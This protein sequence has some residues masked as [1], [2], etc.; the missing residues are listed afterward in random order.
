M[1]LA[2]EYSAPTSATSGLQPYGTGRRARDTWHER[3]KRHL[4]S[5]RVV[6]KGDLPGHEFR[7]NQWITG[8]DGGH[9]L[10]GTTPSGKGAGI[11]VGADG[12]V[13]SVFVPEADRGRGIGRELYRQA[14]ERLRAH[15]QQLKSGDT[16]ADSQRLWE[17]AVRR[18]DAERTDHGYRMKKGLPIGALLKAALTTDAAAHEAAA[19]PFN[20]RPHPT[21]AQQSAG[22]YKK[23]TLRVGGFDIRV[24]N[25][26]GSK[27]RPEWPTL[28]SHYGYFSRTAGADGDQVDCF[29]RVGTPRE[30]AGPAFVINQTRED[31]ATFD[32]HKV[33][34]GWHDWDAARAAYLDNY[35]PGWKVGP[36]Y[37]VTLN[38][39]GEWLSSGD[40]SAPYV[41]EPESLLKRDADPYADPYAD[42]VDRLLGALAE[43]MRGLKKDQ[44]G[45]PFHG[46]QYVQVASEKPTSSEEKGV[47]AKVHDLLS[48][49]H[50]FTFD[51]LSKACGSPPE[52]ALKNALSELKN[53]KWAGSKGA[54]AIEKVGGGY[55]VV[56]K[57]EPAA[58]AP[59]AADPEEKPQGGKPTGW[60]KSEAEAK[61]VEGLHAAGEKLAEAAKYGKISEIDMATQ[62]FKDE[63]AALMAKWAQANGKGDGTPKP[64]ALFKAD[65]QLAVD[66]AK[67]TKFSDAY[68]QWKQNTALEKAGKFP[69]EETKASEPTKASIEQSNK[70]AL[71]VADHDVEAH[72]TEHTH[73]EYQEVRPANYPSLTAQ[74]FATPPSGG[75]S[76]FA[77]GLA[78]SAAAVT[79]L[80]ETKASTPS[81]AKY[82]VAVGLRKEL[83]A[84]KDAY[85]DYHRLREAVEARGASKPQPGSTDT[86]E[87]KLVS[88]W[89]STSGDTHPLAVAMQVAVRDEFGMHKDDVETHAWKGMAANRATTYASAA[90]KLGVSVT[91]N[92]GGLDAQ[93]LVSF[94]RGLQQFVRAQYS[95]TQRRLAAAGVKELHLVR[96]MKTGGSGVH[97]T[98]L[99]LQPASSFSTS[100]ATAK[101]FGA[102]GSVFLTKIPASQVLGT[103]AT[104][105]GC[106]NESEVVVLA[107]KHTTA[108]RGN[109]NAHRD[110][111]YASAAKELK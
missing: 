39:L 100:Y 107:S 86:L 97:L 61:Y 40:T 69:P 67:G 43:Q 94:K 35:T 105:Y 11:K 74:D 7:G 93:K 38:E 90:A 108:V 25:P 49:G 45:H 79:R 29:V 102:Y 54:L 87:S 10:E 109:A 20:L 2:K 15:G 18:G 92:D 89:A 12:T 88:T 33:M 65:K 50:H 83:D 46:N 59:K 56:K 91:K 80:Q 78:R 47:K 85:A 82:H 14:A 73:R 30:Y 60:T 17:S 9:L 26:A 53:P 32:E 21:P 106:K 104:G 98:G 77:S 48:S 52:K 96:G 16:N 23:G 34:L 3:L 75:N 42:L 111:T 110:T 101:S 58:A 68:G 37:Q 62:A 6:A 84:N 28:S 41:G 64:Q 66:L 55:K 72:L 95:L 27:R 51:E 36:A 76:L 31:G 99:R 8:S 24:E 81:E 70:A 13:H 4:A 57:D 71:A 63:K 44:D 5:S 22:N 1:G 19:S 103:W